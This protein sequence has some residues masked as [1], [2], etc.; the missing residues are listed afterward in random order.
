MKN[1]AKR[2]AP[3]SSPR[4]VSRLMPICFDGGAAITSRPTRSRVSS[5]S[6]RYQEPRPGK[7]RNLPFASRREISR[8]AYPAL[9]RN[10]QKRNRSVEERTV[11]SMQRVDQSCG[12][13]S[14]K[15]PAKPVSKARRQPRSGSGE[16]REEQNEPG[17]ES[18]L[19]WRASMRPEAS[20]LPPLEIRNCCAMNEWP[21]CEGRSAAWARPV[22]GRT[23]PRV[24]FD[25]TGG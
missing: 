6:R 10:Q 19:A 8:R 4:R 20:A 5:S 3:S 14:P 18:T 9:S 21:Q 17:H 23:G 13:K 1:G 24:P 16:F 11:T 7:S 2:P 25:M 15:Q 22:N 12:A